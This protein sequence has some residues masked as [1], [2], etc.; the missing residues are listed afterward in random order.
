MGSGHGTAKSKVAFLESYFV[1]IPFTPYAVSAS[2]TPGT[3]GSSVLHHLP[4]FAQIPAH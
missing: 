2:V 1:L 3:A 4:E